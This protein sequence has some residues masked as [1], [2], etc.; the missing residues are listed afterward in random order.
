MPI[1]PMDILYAKKL[2]SDVKSRA[3]GVLFYHCIRSLGISLDRTN[4][5]REILSVNF[6]HLLDLT[7]LAKNAT[8]GDI[9]ENVTTI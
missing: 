9:L 5:W 4:C 3:Q 1:M 7:A 2:Y 8:K 6:I